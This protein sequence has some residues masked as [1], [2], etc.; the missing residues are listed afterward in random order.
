MNG[1]RKWIV[2]IVDGDEVVICI[3]NEPQY[4]RSCELNRWIKETLNEMVSYAWQKTRGRKMKS[5]SEYS[6]EKI[7]RWA[8]QCSRKPWITLD[9]GQSNLNHNETVQSFTV[10]LI[11][12]AGL[13]IHWLLLKWYLLLWQCNEFIVILCHVLQIWCSIDQRNES[14]KSH[15]TQL[16]IQRD[17]RFLVIKARPR[18]SNVLAKYGSARRRALDSSSTVEPTHLPNS[19][20]IYTTISINKGNL[21]CATIRRYN[22]TKSSNRR[23]T[24]WDHG[25]SVVL[26]SGS[27]SSLTKNELPNGLRLENWNIITIL[28]TK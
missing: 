2:S 10:F 8:L 13:Q 19:V 9:Y 17:V 15:L 18:Q 1:D 3:F 5:K 28:Q 23:A 22:Y 26:F 21:S 16:R 27:L 4:Y 24:H 20:C 11:P 6:K 7:I 12:S 25:R 14:E